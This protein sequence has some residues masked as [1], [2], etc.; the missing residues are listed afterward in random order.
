MA[1]AGFTWNLSPASAELL[2]IVLRDVMLDRPP[3]KT[4]QHLAELFF[5]DIDAFLKVVPNGFS[6]SPVRTYA[7]SQEGVG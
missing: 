4:T 5:N 7:A 3:G 1:L 2:A 6:P